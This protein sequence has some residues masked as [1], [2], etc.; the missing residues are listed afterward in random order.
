ME[1]CVMTCDWFE[2][3]H[4]FSVYVQHLGR[5]C[6]IMY[7]LHVPS[8]F[9]P[10]EQKL[11]LTEFVLLEKPNAWDDSVT[12]TATAKTTIWGRQQWHCGYIKDDIYIVSHFF[13]ENS[14]M[15]Y[16][17]SYLHVSTEQ[18]TGRVLFYLDYLISDT[19][20]C[21][22]TSLIYEVQQDLIYRV[23]IVA[24]SWTKWGFSVS[25]LF[26]CIK[27]TFKNVCLNHSS[28]LMSSHLSI[29]V[30]NYLSHVNSDFRQI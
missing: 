25:E 10:R 3:N 5:T 23:F 8:A 12:N 30:S 24:R 27:E 15:A 2:N 28:H 7:E 17:H 20:I 4:L 19:F 6:C 22:E 14:H 18:I 1:V 29:L 13:T 11:R 9:Q 26:K 21:S 16:L